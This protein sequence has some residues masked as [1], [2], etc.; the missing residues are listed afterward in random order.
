M[1]E[2]NTKNVDMSELV[3]NANLKFARSEIKS[4]IRSVK[5][6]LKYRQTDDKL[7]NMMLSMGKMCDE[8]EGRSTRLKKG[9]EGGICSTS[10]G[11]IHEGKQ[12]D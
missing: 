2:I 3:Q 4:A 7:V 1:N 11:I 5:K 6:L 10:P 8:L 12:H 9:C